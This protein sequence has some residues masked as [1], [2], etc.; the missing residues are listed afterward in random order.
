M[1]LKAARSLFAGIAALLLLSACGG[2]GV[3]GGPTNIFP[4][5]NAGS[6]QAV[7]SGVTVT[8]DGSA[9]A[10][11]DGSIA[12]YSWT[13][14]GGTA[15]TLANAGT[16]QPTFV[17]PQVTAT[18]TLSFR[19]VVTDNRG[20]S[21]SAST[22]SV[23]VSSTSAGVVTVAGVVRFARVPF[24]T[25]APFGL[26]YA[27][28][29]LRPLREVTLRVLDAASQ[30]QLATGRTDASG[31]YSFDVP[32]N[33]SVVI[34]VVARLQKDGG[35]PG[36]RWNVRVQDGTGNLTPHSYNTPAFNT[37]AGTQNIDIPTGITAAGAAS[38]PRASGAFAIL[39]TIYTAMQAIVAVA[40]DT[41][42]PTLYVNWGSQAG[43]TFFSP[44][45]Q[46]IALLSDLSED[47]DEFDQ[48]V[49][50]H[51]FGHYIENNFS[52]SD[53]LGGSHSLGDRLDMRIAFGEG[54][55]YGFAAIVLNDPIALD[56]Y[57]NPGTSAHSSSGF[58]V[59]TNPPTG[60]GFN[61]GCW[62]SESSVWSIIW[63]LYD[64]V[65]P[66]DND[67]IQIG[68]AP[69][70]QVLTGAQRTTPAMTSIFSFAAVLKQARPGDVA[71]IDALLEA[72]NIDSAGID[73]FASTQ[74]QAPY[75]LMLPLYASIT[76][77]T[78]VTV[79]SIDDGGR[80][81]KAGNRAFLR[82]TPATSGTAN[83]SVVTSNVNATADPDFLVWVAGTPV[84]EAV[85]SPDLEPVRT[86]TGSLAV[87]A[88][89]TYIIDAY[90]CANGCEPD[91]PQGTS[92]D[93]NLTV[94]IN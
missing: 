27:N 49:V 42:F 54:F 8:L 15:V 24:L 48:H 94:T 67:S 84:L 60:P 50:A 56:S 22:V 85:S 35:P 68:F 46:Y 3:E 73:A 64:P 87:T 80:Y 62:C 78:P 38:G 91:P 66:G 33:T 86:E 23:T 13:Q 1:H 76:L 31:A 17:A 72:Q 21:S 5:A 83:I 52:R 40:P 58:N 63:D 55:G 2:G 93:Y 11:A 65:S 79:R 61:T 19:L 43:G 20:A 29:V 12:S 88:G 92:G 47:T 70:W 18:T 7:V 53:S 90:D 82:Y 6:A 34:Q 89:Q 37:S 10:D 74:T 9:S 14:T 16:A 75:G 45:G 51:E 59:E 4:S 30:A 71:G 81:N 41:T 57:F 77:G 32:G 39:D 36:P 28:P 44:S 69:I 25:S 26:D